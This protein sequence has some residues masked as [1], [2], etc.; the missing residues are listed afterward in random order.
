MGILRSRS[1]RHRPIEDDG[2]R[3][4]IALVNEARTPKELSD[5]LRRSSFERADADP[6][7]VRPHALERLARQFRSTERS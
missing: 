5:V 4:L 2:D 7:D 1:P 3:L 6:R